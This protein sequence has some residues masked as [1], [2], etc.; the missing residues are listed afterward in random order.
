MAV[1]DARYFPRKL[2]QSRN[3][4]GMARSI[5]AFSC[6]WCRKPFQPGQMRFP[7][8]TDCSVGWE[9][10]SLCMDCFKCASA[11]ET[12]E[13]WQRR[14]ERECRGCNEP[15]LTPIHKP[16]HEQV[17][18]R[19]CYQRVYRKRRHD[20]GGGSAIDWKSKKRRCEACKKPLPKEQRYDSKFCSNR[21]R[22]WAYRMREHL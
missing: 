22:Q 15:M 2:S 7:V 16:F 13:K 4:A 21:C 20:N 5:E 14:Y 18:S 1:T 9:L 19:R 12:H 3:D 8:T 6:H 10:V 17:C 11:E